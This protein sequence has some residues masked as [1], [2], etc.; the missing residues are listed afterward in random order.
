MSVVVSNKS[1]LFMRLMWIVLLFYNRRHCRI[2][3][4]WSLK[5]H[6]IT[7]ARHLLSMIRFCITIHYLLTPLYLSYI[8]EI[9]SSGVTKGVHPTFS[10]TLLISEMYTFWSACLQSC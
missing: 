2:I 5:C 1:L 6:R 8:R 3:F 9:P 10:F 7:F 4:H